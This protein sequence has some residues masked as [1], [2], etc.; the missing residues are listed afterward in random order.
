MSDIYERI[1]KLCNEKEITGYRLAKEIGIMPGFLSD[2]KYGRQKGLSAA[3]A[4]K[5]AN[6]FGVTV[7]YLLTGEEKTPDTESAEREVLD[8][9]K[10]NE[11]QK[12]AIQDIIKLTPQQAAVVAPMLE[13]LVSDAQDRDN[14]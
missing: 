13:S 6:Y 11:A 10:L 4:N 2:L 7:D 1:T 5:I 8:L 14:Q 9:S 3:K 12:K